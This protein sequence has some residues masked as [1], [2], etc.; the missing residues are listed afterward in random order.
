MADKL[1]SFL[2]A[3][4]ERSI[5]PRLTRFTEK[6]AHIYSWSTKGSLPKGLEVEDIVIGAIE[7]TLAGLD[8]SEVKKGVR[9][10]NPEKCPD[11]LSFLMGVVR[12]DISALANSHDHQRTER[13]EDGEDET[14]KIVDVD[15]LQDQDGV[16]ADNSR[17]DELMEELK[18]RISDDQEVLQIV[19]ATEELINSS[20]EA[21]SE[22]VMQLT[23]FSETQYRNARRRLFSVVKSLPSMRK[24]N[25]RDE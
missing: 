1:E 19:A 6:W 17:Y 11:L 9:R 2:S 21:T 18:P 10:W 14:N 8:G 22:M 25:G 23:G 24:E 4:W 16:T 7:K 15:H 5:L 20:E 13:S 12:S 3:D